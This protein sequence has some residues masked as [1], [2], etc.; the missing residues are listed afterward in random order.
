MKINNRG[1]GYR[2]MA[3]LLFILACFFFFF[4]YYIYNYY[5]DIKGDYRNINSNYVEGR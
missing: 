5:V 1:W 3:F 2:M 4:F